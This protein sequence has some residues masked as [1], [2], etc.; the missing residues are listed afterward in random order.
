MTIAHGENFSKQF[1]QSVQFA[2]KLI[3]VISRGI[4]MRLCAVSHQRLHLDNF[5]RL[6]VP[7]KPS[8]YLSCCQQEQEHLCADGNR[9]TRRRFRGV[10]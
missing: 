8:G 9:A 5:I 3:V 6:I 1:P 10:Q 4:P 2:G 7:W